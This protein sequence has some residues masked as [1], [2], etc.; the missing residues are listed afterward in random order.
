MVSKEIDMWIIRKYMAH[1]IRRLGNPTDV[2][3]EQIQKNGLPD[4]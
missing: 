1:F 4:G 2:L 3:P